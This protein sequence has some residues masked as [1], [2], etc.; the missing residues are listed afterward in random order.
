M[1]GVVAG[2][3]LHP[4]VEAEHVGAGGG[5]VLEGTREADQGGAGEAL[6]CRVVCDQLGAADD[7][8]GVH[9][10][11][12]AQPADRE[13]D[14]ADRD[15]EHGADREQDQKTDRREEPH[16]GIVA[17]QAGPRNLAVAA[18]CASR[19]GRRAASCGR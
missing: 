4:D 8:V 12:G 1:G 6:G 15:A 5:L 2:G 13:D 7:T 19:S 18:T 10:A 3:A 14:Q 17:R 9:G 11:R 16:L